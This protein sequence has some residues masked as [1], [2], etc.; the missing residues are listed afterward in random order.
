MFASIKVSDYGGELIYGEAGG[1]YTI[2]LNKTREIS[3]VRLLAE[4]LILT[5]TVKYTAFKVLFPQF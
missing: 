1:I 3:Q 4:L 2:F 5:G